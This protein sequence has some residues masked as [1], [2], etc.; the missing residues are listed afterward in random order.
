MFEAL[1]RGYL[2]LGRRFPDQ[3]GE[4]VPRLLRQTDH[5]RNRHSLSHGLSGGRH[6]FQ[7]ASRRTQPRPLPH[8]V[9]TGR[10]HRAAGRK[11]EP[12]G[13]VNLIGRVAQVPRNWAPGKAITEPQLLSASRKN[14]FALATSLNICAFSASGVGHSISPRSRAETPVEAASSHPTRSAQNPEC[15]T[16]RQT[17]PRQR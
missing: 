11:N 9:Q 3:G 15:A 4:A 10:V 7:G 8:A 12:A 14:F 16:P 13:G 17:T 6:L 5:V 2:E 1:V